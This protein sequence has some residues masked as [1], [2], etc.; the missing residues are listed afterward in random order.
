ML[1][2]IDGGGRLWEPAGIWRSS[3][4]HSLYGWTPTIQLVRWAFVVLVVSLLI[5]LILMVVSP[6]SALVQHVSQ[7]ALVVVLVAVAWIAGT[8]GVARSQRQASGRAAG[9]PWRVMGGAPLDP[10]QAD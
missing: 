4:S 9:N 10:T 2:A 6:S 1:A 3:Q 7:A 8:I 5:P